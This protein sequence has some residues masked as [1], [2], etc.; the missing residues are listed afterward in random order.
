[1]PV[2]GLSEKEKDTCP[3]PGR[4]EKESLTEKEIRKH[5]EERA[6]RNGLQAVMG[7]RHSRTRNVLESGKLKKTIFSF[8]KGFYED[9]EVFELGFGTGRMT[10]EL[11]KK[12]YSVEGIE[13]SEIMFEK[14]SQRFLHTPN[15][16]L[17]KGKLTE[18]ETPEKYDL[19][20][21]SLVLLHILNPKELK[22]PAKKMK[23][24]CRKGGHIFLCEH[25]WEENGRS[26]SKYSIF[27]KK[28]EYAELFK[29]LELV[30]GMD[31]RCNG[32]L[33]SLHLFRK[34]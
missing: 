19:V 33:F 32:D 7:L 34:N 16:E 9:K 10:Q 27:R 20:F 28:E 14:S 23:E 3:E 24:I 8:L 5:W 13:P 17:H 2:H 11:V 18:F 30:K 29:G 4:K 22:K 1:M 12:A 6:K 25:V 15:I 31:T 21:E 26:G